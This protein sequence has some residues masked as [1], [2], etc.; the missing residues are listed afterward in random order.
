M[1]VSF[2]SVRLVLKV[3]SFLPL[4]VQRCGFE[5]LLMMACSL[6]MSQRVSATKVSISSF[7]E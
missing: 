5:L 2:S 4:P 1:L 3:S 6:V 7:T